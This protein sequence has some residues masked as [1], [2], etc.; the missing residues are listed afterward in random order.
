M[1]NLKPLIKSL[2]I[3]T[4]HALLVAAFILAIAAISDGATHAAEKIGV[5]TDHTEFLAIKYALELPFFLGILVLVIAESIE[6]IKNL[7]SI[8]K[9]NLAASNGGVVGT[10]H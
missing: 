7:K 9:A 3:L 5:E 4:S 8:L 10:P 2:L 6:Q 1:N